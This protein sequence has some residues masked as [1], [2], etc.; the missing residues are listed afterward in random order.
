LEPHHRNSHSFND[1]FSSIY[2]ISST[3]FSDLIRGRK[4]E[5]SF[6]RSFDRLGFQVI[7]QRRG[8]RHPSADCNGTQYLFEKQDHDSELNYLSVK[9]HYFFYPFAINQDQSV[10]AYIVQVKS[11][12]VTLNPNDFTSIP[13]SIRII[14][15]DFKKEKKYVLRTNLSELRAERHNTNDLIPTKKVTFS[16]EEVKEPSSWRRLSS[17]RSKRSSTT[18]S[19]TP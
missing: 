11:N 12:K 2:K 17:F 19:T 5:V 1:N 6:S 10:G 18:P 13:A 3:F 4:I 15:E 9:T 8:I 7:V 16:L 14:G